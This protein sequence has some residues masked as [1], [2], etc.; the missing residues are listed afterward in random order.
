LPL[1]SVKAP[2]AM[3]AFSAPSLVMPLIVK[4]AVVL[5][6]RNVTPVTDAPASPDSTKSLV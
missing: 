3:L 2:A 4:R 6:F 1:V 5:P